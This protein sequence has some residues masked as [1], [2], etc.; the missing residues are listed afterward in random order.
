MRFGVDDASGDRELHEE[1]GRKFL[2]LQGKESRTQLYG[3]RPQH[4]EEHFSTATSCSKS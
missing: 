4:E 3:A 2:M 1:K